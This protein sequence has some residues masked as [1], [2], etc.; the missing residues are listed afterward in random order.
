MSGLEPLDKG[1]QRI[2]KFGAN[3]TVG[4]S[5]AVIASAGVYQTPTTAVS[6]EIVSDDANDTSAG[7]GA[8]KVMVQ[9]IGEDWTELE[10]EVT[11]NGTTPVALP[12]DFRRVFRLFVTES[13]TYGTPTLGSHAGTITLRV[14]GA[15]ATWAEINVD[16][17][18][19]SGQSLIAAYTVPKG[20]VA[21]IASH[22]V[23]ADDNSRLS[24]QLVVREGSDI[25]TAPFTGSRTRVF[26]AGVKNQYAQNYAAV[27]G[28]FRGPADISWIGKASSGTVDASAEFTLLL[29]N[30]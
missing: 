25:V 6:L 26:S 23:F 2:H 1:Y 13:G 24:V 20:K 10:H 14:A 27:L 21:Y 30:G 29:K 12:V 5:Y 8:R 22:D 17:T 7:T 9:G 19:P 16:G 4:T 15:G 11:L 28:P 3:A 18:R